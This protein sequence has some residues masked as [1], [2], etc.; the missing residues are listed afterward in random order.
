[1]DEKD[2]PRIS[3]TKDK[4]HYY[5]SDGP[6]VEWRH[7]EDLLKQLAEA[8]NGEQFFRNLL[9]KRGPSYQGR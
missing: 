1:M 5:D 9:S 2:I 4:G 8:R 3:W 7:V 6:F